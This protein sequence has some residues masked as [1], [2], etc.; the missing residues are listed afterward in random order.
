MKSFAVGVTGWGQDYIVLLVS[1]PVTRL[2]LKSVAVGVTGWGQAY[3]VLLVSFP[4]TQASTKV[5]SHS[6]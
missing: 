6:Q 1:F 5:C 4:V 2:V 3:I